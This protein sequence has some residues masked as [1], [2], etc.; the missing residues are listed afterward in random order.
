MSLE[1]WDDSRF[2]S[3]LC[4]TLNFLAFA[5][6]A[7]SSKQV[8]RVNV[9]KNLSSRSYGMSFTSSLIPSNSASTT[10]NTIFH[11]STKNKSIT[12]VENSMG[13]SYENNVAIH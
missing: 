9:F 4:V 7:S 10:L 5:I 6:S 11:P 8:L 12:R 13:R 3:I 2:L 1:R